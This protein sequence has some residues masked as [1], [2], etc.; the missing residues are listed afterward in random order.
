MPHLI[1]IQSLSQSDIAS[2][3]NRANHHL[4][5]TLAKNG[6]CQNHDGIAAANL[7]FESSTRTLNSFQL[8]QMRHN[9]LVL[10]PHLASSALNKG[11]SLSD[12]LLN[13]EAMG[14]SLFVMRHSDSLVLESACQQLREDSYVIN[15]GSGSVHHPTQALL[16]IFT[17][18]QLKPQIDQLSI[19]IVGDLKHSRVARSLVDG[20]QVLGAK[21]IRLVSPPEWSLPLNAGAHYHTNE[22][23][24]GLRQADV[25]ICLRVQKERFSKDESLNADQYH[26]QYGLNTHWLTYAKPDAIVMHPGPM[27]RGIEITSD[28]ADGPQSVI[29][30]QV[31][32]GVAV[33]MAVIDYVLGTL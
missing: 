4:T 8:A 30:Q 23:K 29:L 11:E 7:F 28:V 21:D 33:R 24:D 19:A 16:D 27:N 18:S 26:Q 14:V 25:V 31:T 5:H 2:I 3:L 13:L 12:T 6:R 17:I 1:N 32:N 15:A 22:L 9:M 10:S 20:L